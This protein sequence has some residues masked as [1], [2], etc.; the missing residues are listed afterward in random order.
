[1]RV[2]LN[3]FEINIWIYLFPGH[4]DPITWKYHKIESKVAPW[5]KLVELL[6]ILLRIIKGMRESPSVESL[7]KICEKKALDK[8]LLKKCC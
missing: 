7:G 6:D 1:M 3:F 4:H 2:S 5:K 8:G